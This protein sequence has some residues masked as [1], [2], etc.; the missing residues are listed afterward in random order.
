MSV[1][2][3][4]A[5]SFASAVHS[6]YVLRQKEQT[7]QIMSVIPVFA[8]SSASSL[9]L[10]YVLQQQTQTEQCY[11]NLFDV[12]RAS[13]RRLERS[14]SLFVRAGGG[15]QTGSPVHSAY[16][17]RQTTHTEVPT[18]THCNEVSTRQHR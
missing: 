11:D 1:M 16:V 7:N 18:G 9:Y 15:V 5:N 17:L 8:N 4:S 13:A 3:V 2:P 6:A 12:G 10:A 14:A